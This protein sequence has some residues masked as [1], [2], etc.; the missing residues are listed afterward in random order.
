MN[1]LDSRRGFYEGYELVSP[2]PDSRSTT[3]LRRPDVLMGPETALDGGSLVKSGCSFY[4]SA[5]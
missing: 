5:R 1:C 3:S 2:N 4:L